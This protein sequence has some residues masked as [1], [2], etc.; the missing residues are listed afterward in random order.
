MPDT[1]SFVSLADLKAKR[2]A[3][4][5]PA[6]SGCG[7]VASAGKAGCGSATA[8]DTMPAHVWDRIK[9][10]PC[11]SEDAHHH[12]ARM[13][14]AVAPACNIQC[15]YCNR[16]YDCSNE[17][18]P[19]VVSRKLT[20]QEAADKVIAVARKIPQLSVV[21][22]AGPGDAL[23][24]PAKTFE[25]FRL[26]RAAAPDIRLCL[27]TNGLALPDYADEI[28][29]AG[30]DHVTITVNA[31]DPQVG[32]RIYPWIFHDHDRITG[33]EAARILLA[34]QMEGLEKLVARGVLVKIN[35]VLIP[36]VNDR[37]LVDVNRAVK[38]R[39]AFLHNIM[40]LIS[41]AAHGTH[42]GLTGQRGP[43]AQELKAVQDACGDGANLMRHCRQCRADAVGMLGEDRSADFTEFES[44]LAQPEEDMEARRQYR[45]TVEATR[46]AQRTATAAAQAALQQSPANA[47]L[48]PLLVA[49]ATKGGG[50]VN[51]HFGHAS[52]FQIYEVTDAATRLI[53]HRRVE[54]YCQGGYGEDDTLPATLTALNDC[55]AVLVAKIGGCPRAELRA[56]GIEPVEAFAHRFIEEATL[57]W[58]AD[59]RDR[60]RRG[61]AEYHARP[62]AVLR[63]DTRA[64]SA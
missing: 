47:S 37:H 54:H 27:S 46:T 14:V 60:V 40:P 32:A 52:E 59:F 64:A 3:L 63:S 23:A 21:G 8:P 36:G 49:V 57:A 38:A 45:E 34:R 29:A 42:Y 30:V 2:V 17:S 6:A 19:G 26:L 35:S 48:P 51:Q 20:P 4:A 41:D 7:S 44:V 24:N 28:A 15:H 22:I 62:D 16:K 53:G 43:S 12:Y 31:I 39:G 1:A 5:Q 13:H 25:T 58:R 33:V 18:R 11:Y 50:R 9:D 10:H 61:E 56:A 55:H